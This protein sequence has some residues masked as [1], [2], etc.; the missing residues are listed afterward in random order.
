M[1]KV[2]LIYGDG[3]ILHTHVNINPFAEEEKDGEIIRGDVTNLDKYVDDGELEELIAYDVLDYIESIKAEDS[4]ANWVK[5][6]KIGGKIC[7]G[8]TDLI[9]VCKS[10][11]QYRIDINLAN[12]LIHGT[13]EKPYLIRRVNFTAIGLADYLQVQFGLKIGRKVVNNYKMLVEAHRA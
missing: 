2:N 6:I 5:K 13:Q 3:D 9:E 8:G 11:S 4:I 10:F 7:I 12:E 1:E